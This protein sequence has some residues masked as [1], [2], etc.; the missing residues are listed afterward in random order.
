MLIL[1]YGLE[2]NFGWATATLAHSL[3]LAIA[4]GA[5]GSCSAAWAVLSFLSVGTEIEPASKA[6]KNLVTRGPFGVTRNPMY[7]GLILMT[8]GIAF[9]R[10]TASFFL[11]PVSVALVCNF[12]FI[13]FEEAKM[14]SQYGDLFTEYRA[15]VRRW[16]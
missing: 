5:L 8:L 10:G 13:P 9:Y 4:I 16:I 2:H 14:Q 3:P 12:I 1:A 11:V 15:K 7:L 6:N